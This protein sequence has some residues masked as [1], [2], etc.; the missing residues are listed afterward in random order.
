MHNVVLTYNKALVRQAVLS[1]WWR[2]VGL[3]FFIALAILA[4]SL[5]MFIRDGDT[6]WRVGVLATVLGMGIVFIVA[7]YLVHYRN[8]L[9]RFMAMGSP[10]ASLDISD[11]AFSVTSGAGSATIPWSTVT[12]VWRFKSHWLL[13]LSKS[14]FMTLPTA[15]MPPDAGAFI[16]ARVAAAGGK[17]A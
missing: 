4:T 5:A 11:A 16:L 1:F 3:K 2:V 14:Q 9:Q 13:L 15:G 6:S 8:A 10:L 7:L 17:I 12:E